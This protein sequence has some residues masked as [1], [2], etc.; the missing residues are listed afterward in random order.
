MFQIISY[1]KYN[2]NIKGDIGIINDFENNKKCIKKKN[3][4]IYD[5]NNIKIIYMMG[6]IKNE[7]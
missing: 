2:T 7:A 1:N 6:V 4:Y 3:K 5:E